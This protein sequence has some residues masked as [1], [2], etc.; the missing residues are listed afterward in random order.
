VLAHL[1]AG[2][3]RSTALMHEDKKDRII[4]ALLTII[5]SLIEIIKT[6]I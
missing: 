4:V 5:V 1:L 6:L 3:E 2:L